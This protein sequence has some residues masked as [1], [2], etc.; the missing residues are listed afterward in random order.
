MSGEG[1]DRPDSERGKD[2]GHLSLT[3][4]FF[5]SWLQFHLLLALTE[6]KA[7]L[8]FIPGHLDFYCKLREQI[9]F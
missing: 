7:S 3:R 2:R 8:V 6:G 4:V 1:G 9:K 5:L